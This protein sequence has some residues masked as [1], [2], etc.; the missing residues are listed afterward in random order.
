MSTGKCD[1]CGS[2]RIFKAAYMLFT[3][4]S[5]EVNDAMKLAGYSKRELTS[6]RIQKSISKKKCR[7][8]QQNEVNGKKKGSKPAS[9]VSLSI[10]RSSLSDITNSSESKQ[11]GVRIF[12]G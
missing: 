1:V 8:Q 5:M 12:T 9:I 3:N 4:P 2:P 7:L 10:K 11:N 6:R